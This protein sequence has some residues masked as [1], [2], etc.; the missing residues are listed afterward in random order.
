MSASQLGSGDEV[1]RTGVY[2]V[3]ELL[4]DIF[5][6]CC[7]LRSALAPSKPASL[8]KHSWEATV[9]LVLRDSILFAS[10]FWHTARNSYDL[11][12]TLRIST[13]PVHLSIVCVL[14]PSSRSTLGTAKSISTTP[15]RAVQRGTYPKHGPSTSS[16]D[17]YH[18]SRR[19]ILVRQVRTLRRPH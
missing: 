2:A 14:A 18:L 3:W 15:S 19:W 9:P 16:N 13:Q 7:N 4:F 10:G 5:R 6:R 11:F 1:S 8:L 12:G 17:R